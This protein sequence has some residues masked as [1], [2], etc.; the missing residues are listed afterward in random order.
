M[1][2]NILAPFPYF[3]AKQ[4]MV[5]TLLSLLPDHKV[6]VEVF[7]GAA[8]L[9]FS[10]APAPLEI[11]NDIDSDL[12]NFFRVL[13]DPTK[14]EHLQAQLQ[15]TPYSREE[16]QECSKAYKAGNTPDLVEQVRIFYTVIYQSFSCT[17]SSHSWRHSCTDGTNVA[18]SFANAIDALPL[19]TSRLRGIQIE[20]DDFA[21]IH[22]SRCHDCSQRVAWPR[23]VSST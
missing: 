12:V 10:K 23:G 9:L 2:R 14:T 1:R 4:Y 16:W 6:Y 21:K 17:I 15:L 8:S 13:R 11:Y 5:P 7:G 3:G 19:F 22:S 18:R 20:H